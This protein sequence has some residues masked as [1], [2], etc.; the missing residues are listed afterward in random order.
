[1]FAAIRGTEPVH[2]RRNL[3]RYS[4]GRATR[5]GAVSCRTP[6]VRVLLAIG[7]TRAPKCR[8]LLNALAPRAGEAGRTRLVRAHH[9]IGGALAATA[10]ADRVFGTF[11]AK[12]KRNRL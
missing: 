6:D 5:S 11:D 7:K 12:A 8:H 3:A 9:H 2:H 1:M 4:T 10:D